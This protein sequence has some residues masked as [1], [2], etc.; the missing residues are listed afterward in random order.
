MNSPKLAF[1]CLPFALLVP[2]ALHDLAPRA[3][4]AVVIAVD[5]FGRPVPGLEL[6][7]VL[8]GKDGKL[9]RSTE[10]PSAK[11]GKARVKVGEAALAD[12]NVKGEHG[13]VARTTWSES[14]TTHLLLTVAPLVDVEV[15]L[16]DTADALVPRFAAVLANQGARQ[17]PP[18]FHDGADT[19]EFGALSNGEGALR[20]RATRGS[21]D[22]EALV[23][24]AF[25]FSALH[26]RIQEGYGLRADDLCFVD[27]RTTQLT[28]RLPTMAERTITWL[29]PDEAT[30][31][32]I[33]WYAAHP[34]LESFAEYVEHFSSPADAAGVTT[35][36]EP[37]EDGELK[38][39]DDAVL[40]ARRG[41]DRFRL[42]TPPVPESGLRA[43]LAEPDV[44]VTAP[45]PPEGFVFTWSSSN[46][47]DVRRP[48]AFGEAP[49][50]AAGQNS[51]WLAPLSENDLDR[52]VRLDTSLYGPID[53]EVKFAALDT[54]VD[55]SALPKGRWALESF[56]VLVDEDDAYV[57][58][59]DW[60]VLNADGRAETFGT[61]SPDT[62]SI[63]HTGVGLAAP[64]IDLEQREDGSLA[65][66]GAGAPVEVEFVRTDGSPAAFVSFI[67]R[68][69]SKDD[70]FRQVETRRAWTDENG[71][72]TLVT[73]LEEGQQLLVSI[74]PDEALPGTTLFSN[75][76]VEGRQRFVVP[77]LGTLTLDA[78][79]L[80]GGEP[81]ALHAR[82][83]RHVDGD[84]S[85]V[86]DRVDCSP[87]YITSLDGTL[88][89]ED[90]PVGTY[91]VELREISMLGRSTGDPK[92]VVVEPK[93]TKKR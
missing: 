44:A 59:N 58:V 24:G 25:A 64:R 34:L 67:A 81:R 70:F 50:V 84:T 38:R 47:Y 88:V 65:A 68:P 55:L 45:L 1:A 15:T 23:P 69:W 56:T 75:E 7:V 83:A 11:T 22:L 9:T 21:T 93:S 28:L 10:K 42:T 63:T 54:I 91:L 19:S 52:L 12:V 20:L 36:L 13:V 77:E 32:T 39:G 35:V 60:V 27:T 30:D 51:L 14:G 2:V 40:V 78:V 66:I 90:V 73:T 8:R 74:A 61:A 79:S 29:G 62:S 57:D 26:G 87:T 4:D 3:N 85:D 49:T 76:M 92:T 5:A 43:T 48:V 86:G 18:L 80:V 33:R 46:S 6:E 53:S 41:A 16:L 31:A 17:S 71:R 37:I 72:A 89:V 82:L